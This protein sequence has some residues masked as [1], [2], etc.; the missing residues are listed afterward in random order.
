MSEN[1]ATHEAKVMAEVARTTAHEV[2]VSI[3][4]AAMRIAVGMNP[5]KR[6]TAGDVLAFLFVMARARKLI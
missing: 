6:W 2:A 4:M 1:F 5:G 3:G